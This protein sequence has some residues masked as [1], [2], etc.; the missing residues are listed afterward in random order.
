MTPWNRYLG[1]GMEVGDGE[2]AAVIVNGHASVRRIYTS[3]SVTVL[4]SD[5]PANPPIISST[6]EVH[7]VGKVVEARFKLA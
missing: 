2:V 1:L 6:R 5:N 7:I 3:G 4:N